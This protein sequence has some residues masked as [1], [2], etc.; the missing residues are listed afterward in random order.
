MNVVSAMEET[1]LFGPGIPPA[2]NRLLQQAV[3]LRSHN[4]AEAERLFWQARAEDPCCLPVYF[5]LYK[6][7]A[8]GKRLADAERAVRLALSEAS[9]QGGFPLSWRELAEAPERYPLYTDEISL[10]YLFSLKALAF[11]TLRQGRTDEAAAILIA[12]QALDPEDRVG[13]SVIRALADSLAPEFEE[14][15]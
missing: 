3:A 15:A 7:Y 5:A 12:L 9:R 1:V 14:A 8:N 2:T 10:F 4:R 6:F 11:V 13:G